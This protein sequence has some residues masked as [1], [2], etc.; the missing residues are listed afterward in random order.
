MDYYAINSL[1]ENHAGWSLLRAQNAPLAVHFFM[2]AFTDPNQRN[3][4]RQQLIDVLEDVLFGVRESFGEDKFPRPASEYLDDW[5]DPER[6]RAGNRRSALAAFRRAVPDRAAASHPCEP[7]ARL[8]RAV[9]PARQRCAAALTA[10]AQA[11]ATLARSC[12]P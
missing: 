2:A 11:T 12:R 4:G 8:R 10:V 3:I 1:R 6:V 9:L 5:A 7:S